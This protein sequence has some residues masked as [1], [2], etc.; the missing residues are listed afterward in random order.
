LESVE[1]KAVAVDPD[2]L[3]TDFLKPLPI[4]KA[5]A[6]PRRAVMVSADD[7]Q[8]AFERTQKRNHP[9]DLPVLPKIRVQIQKVAGNADERIAWADLA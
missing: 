8:G 4:L 2:T 5:G 9:V 3:P 1:L 7:G 6:L